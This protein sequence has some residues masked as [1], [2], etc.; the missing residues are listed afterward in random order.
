MYKCKY[1]GKEYEKQSSMAAHTGRCKNNPNREANIQKT[2][3]YVKKANAKHI[4]NLKNDPKRQKRTYTFKCKKCGKEY[5]LELSQLEFE[6]GNYKKYCSRGC[7]NSRDY[8][9][10]NIDKYKLKVFKPCVNC[11]AEVEVN[12]RLAKDKVLCDECKKNQYIL[13]N[14][15]GCTCQICNRK[16]RYIFGLNTRHFCSQTCQEEYNNNISKYLSDE[17]KEKLSEAGR[18]AAQILKDVKRSKNEI[19]F[20]ELCEKYFNKVDHNIAIFNG[21]DADV[22]IYDINYAILWNGKWHYEEMNL[23]NSHTS[24]AKIQNRDKIKQ[25]E[26]EDSG[27]TCY[28][29]KDLGSEDKDFVEKEFNNFISKLKEDNILPR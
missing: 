19:Y 21:W 10:K 3:Q 29:I 14:T 23:K 25:K 17:V 16:Y 22:I 2:N 1:C 12:T 4:E 7:A 6:R 24:L 18:K 15:V 20:C 28:I 26:I 13:G 27:F 8:A 11:G 5:T 9:F